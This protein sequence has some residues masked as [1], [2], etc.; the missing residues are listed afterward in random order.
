M[1]HADEL[2]SILKDVALEG[3]VVINKRKL[4]WLLGWGQDR[5]GAWSGLL[6]LWEAINEDRGKLMGLEVGDKIVLTMPVPNNNCRHQAVSAWAPSA[7]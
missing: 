3:A 1:A 7:T 5:P 4:L 6:D 2:K